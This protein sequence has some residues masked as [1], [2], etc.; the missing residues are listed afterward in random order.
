MTSVVPLDEGWRL[1]GF[2]G[3][4]WQL[5]RAQLHARE[6]RGGA[7]VPARAEP[8]LRMGAAAHLGVPDP[9]GDPRARAG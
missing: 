8:A 6:E 9:S 1:R 2:L 4:D 5:H 7:W 3:D